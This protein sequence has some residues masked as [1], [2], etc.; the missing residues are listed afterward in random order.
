MGDSDKT[1][2]RDSDERL[3]R[4]TRTRGS[5]ERLGR[6]TQARDSD[7]RLGRETRTRDLDERLGVHD[8]PGGGLPSGMREVAAVDLDVCRSR[9]GCPP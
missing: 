9:L 7:E 6:E 5:D 1:Q 4:E 2:A 8:L 3:G